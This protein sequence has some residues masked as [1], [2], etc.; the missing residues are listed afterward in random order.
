MLF[1]FK[2]VVKDSTERPKSVPSEKVPDKS[3]RIH[4][5]DPLQASDLEVA[6]QWHRPELSPD[7]S[8]TFLF[9]MNNKGVSI[10]DKP[11]SFAAFVTVNQIRVTVPEELHHD[12]TELFHTAESELNQQSGK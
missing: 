12:L 1:Q 8:T 6:I 11:T 10:A 9:A 3:D 5:R 4:A 7:S 2:A